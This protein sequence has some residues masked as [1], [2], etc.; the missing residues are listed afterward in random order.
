MGGTK[1]RF[2][3]LLMIKLLIKTI[4]N[5]VTVC[6]FMHEASVKFRFNTL[7]NYCVSFY[8]CVNC[9]NVCV[10]VRINLDTAVS[11]HVDFY[12]AITT[13]QPQT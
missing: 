13:I 3:H 1:V 9:V 2:W 6:N 8:S 11:V 12:N 5:T 10:N 7:Q 4:I